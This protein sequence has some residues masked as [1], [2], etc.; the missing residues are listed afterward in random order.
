MN[1]RELQNAAQAPAEGGGR[2]EIQHVSID[3]NTVSGGTMRALDDINLTVEHGELVAVVGR[4][5]CGKTT[6]MN[7]VAGLV[8]PTAGTCKLNG[9]E[10]QIPSR[11][12][13]VVFQ[14]ETVFGWKRV[15]DNL[16]FALELGGVAK[17]D[18]PALVEQYLKLVKL[19]S[20]ANFYPKELSGG[21]KK[22]LQIAMVLANKP[23]LLLMDEPFGPLD[24][25]TKVELQLEVERI[26]LENP[27]TTFFV[28]HD[29]EEATFVAD[30][31]I[32]IEKGRIIEELKVDIPRP[33]PV[34]V[35]NSPEF[36]AI[37]DYLLGKLLELSDVKVGGN[38]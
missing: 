26:R 37:S 24:Y 10:I 33:R 27:L 5:G 17:Q 13:G 12:R 28:T 21:M 16:D 35:R 19:D 31:I 36:H 23:Q 11:E 18:R 32:M 30:R 20:F 15:K 3:F 6:L 22:R 1:Q 14:A 9:R 34:E 25:A 2:L 7:I 38:A 8:K 4:S 29:V